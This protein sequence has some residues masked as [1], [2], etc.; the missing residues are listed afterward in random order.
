MV[1]LARREFLCKAGVPYTVFSKKKEAMF[2][3]SFKLSFLAASFL[4]CF[5]VLLYE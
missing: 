3:F 2:L 5:R 4:K 1:F